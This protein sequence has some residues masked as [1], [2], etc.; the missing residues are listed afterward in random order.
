MSEA[1]V[2]QAT[3]ATF[4][5]SSDLEAAFRRSMLV[6]VQSNGPAANTRASGIGNE[7]ERAVVYDRVTPA[8]QR[9]RHTPEL[10]AIFELGK[11]FEKI[12]VRRLEDMGAEIVQ[13]GRDY[14]DRRYELSG[15]TDLKLRMPHWPRAV[16]GE[17]KGLNPYT[18]E[19]IE[20]LDDIR[21]SR[22]AWVRK[23]YAQLQMYLFLAG[24]D[25]G[26]FVLFNKSTGWPTF[27]DCPID[28]EYAEKL[29]QRAERV[30][31]HVA[32]GTLPDR[33]LSKECQ[34]C[35][36][37]SVCSPNIDYGDG[38]LILSDP[39]LEALVKRRE[40]L[41]EAASEFKAVDKA[42]KSSL[43]E[44]EGEILIGDFVLTRTAQTRKAHAV[45]ESHF[46]KTDIRLIGSSK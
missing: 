6:L 2:S 21:N 31:L 42:L 30:K 40:E 22:Q 36:F 37:L 25:L 15:H 45:K 46:F 10:Q 24:E 32:N 1:T 19:G 18:G 12:A 13:R 5:P 4:S 17:I 35:Q 29:I 34:R 20:S 16:T 26:V 33:H 41:A 44:R 8:D 28:Y 7:C 27:I 3:T 9:T 11:D 23:Y 38:V 39:E 14:L 43:P